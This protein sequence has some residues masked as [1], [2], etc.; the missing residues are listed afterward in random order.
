MN[1]LTYGG[2]VCG[3]LA[4]CLY[5]ANGFRLKRS[6]SLDLAD[7]ALILFSM[8]GATGAVRLT[9]FVLLGDF[10]RTIKWAPAD[11][12]SLTADD[13]VFVVIGGMCL[14]WVSCQGIWQG[15]RNL[16]PA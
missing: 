4:V 14:L 15:F 12:W 8:V 2:L 10:A 7:A 16:K 11:V 9:G 1:E 3:V 6:G 13:G 5:V